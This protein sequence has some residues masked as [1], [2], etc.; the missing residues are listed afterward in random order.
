M[1]SELAK[2]NSVEAFY[3]GDIAQR[4]ADGFQ[5]NGG[6]VTARD[7]AAYQARVVEPLKLSCGSHTIPHRTADG[8]RIK[9]PADAAR[10]AS[11]E[12][13]EDAPRLAADSRPLG[14]DAPRVARPRHFARRSGFH[15]GSHRE[16]T[17][18]E[19]A[20]ES[21][22]K[23]TAA[24][25]P[26]SSSHTRSRRVLRPAPSTSALPTKHG[27]FVALTLTHGNGFGACVTVEGL[28]LTLGHGMSRF[29]PNPEHPNA[30]GP[31]KRP[32]HNMVPTVVTRDENPV[33]AIGGTGGRKI[34]NAL[35]EVLTQFVVLGQPLAPSIAA[36]RLHTEGDAAVSFEKTW[37]A[38]E[39][40]ALR[41]LGY[42]V[43]T[44]G[45]A[46]MSAVAL[47]NG[48]L[49]QARR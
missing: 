44:G 4:I 18:E 28:G 27:N 11:D 13:G 24:V 32:L 42:N 15:Q 23:I 3:R 46:N 34:P 20:R 39:S 12:L 38:E 33:L 29:D 17:V 37:P 43:T 41:K 40:E 6:M 25:S 8:R 36:P 5:K 14:S 19:Y 48:V 30:P 47:E 9:R 26:E 35:C 49:H 21:A 31:G 16:I 45:S 2:A 7:M 22:D 1:L 10:H